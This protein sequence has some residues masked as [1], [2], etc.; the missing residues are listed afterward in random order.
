MQQILETER[1]RIR[2]LSV[3]DSKFILEL[4]NTEGWLKFIGDRNVKDLLDAIDYIER[5]MKN[6]Q[7]FY[8]VFELKETNQAIGIV[9][10]LQRDELLFPDIGFAILPSY[11]KMGFTYEASSMY[12]HKL[13]ASDAQETILAIT[14]PDNTSS[15]K[16][17]E[18]LGLE[19]D[20]AFMKGNEKLLRYS[21]PK[22]DKR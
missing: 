22:P 1:L 10:L 3:E 2:P 15:I 13:M 18:K 20:G 6:D 12:L 11:E 17:L 9:T 16:L 7:V 5:I 19:A 21:I 8:N 14:L 4:F